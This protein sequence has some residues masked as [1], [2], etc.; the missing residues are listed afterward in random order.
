MPPLPRRAFL[1]AVRSLDERRFR[2]FV[3]DIWAARGYET[4]IDGHRIVVTGPDGKATSLL[5]VADRGWLGRIDR[6]PETDDRVD[7][8]VSVDRHNGGE[9]IATEHH[10]TL[11]DVEELRRITLYAIDRDRAEQLFQTYLNR[12]ATIPPQ[13]DTRFETGR[14]VWGG[15][16]V[17]A[18]VLIAILAAGSVVPWL[19]TSVVGDGSGD[20]TA[21]LQTGAN[22]GDT[23]THPRAE[24]VTDI[25]TGT[26]TETAT[27]DTDV[28]PGSEQTPGWNRPLPAI[29]V[30]DTAWR[31]F[32]FDPAR[33][34]YSR[35]TS[36]PVGNVSIAESVEFDFRFIAS[37]IVVDGRLYATDFGGNLH[38]LNAETM[39]VG[40]RHQLNGRVTAT[41]TVAND[42]LYAA[43]ARS[44]V[45]G[46]RSYA[47]EPA[48][49]LHAI[50][51]D[52]GSTR[53]LRLFEPVVLSSP[54][55]VD[56]TL[57]IGSIEG[58][59]HAVG[60]KNGTN[61]WNTTIGGQLFS[62]PAIAEDTLYIGSTNGGVYAIERTT[63][64]V[65]WT[66]QTNG[67]VLSSPAIV[68]DT[69]YIGSS[70]GRLYALDAETG[71][72]RWNH[73]TGAVI[74]SSPAVAKGRVF[75][76][77]QAGQVYAIDA[78]NG[79]ERWNRTYRGDVLSSP[80][81]ASDTVY[82][83]VE[84]LTEPDNGTRGGIVALDAESG[85]AKWTIE[86]AAPVG[87]S[88][89]VVDGTVFIGDYDGTLYRITG[90]TE[91]ETSSR[92]AVWLANVACN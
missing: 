18:M 51:T 40:W 68:N 12:S 22:P 84:V 32:G 91:L 57:Y 19:P 79:T 65:R 66:V 70:D 75:V 92:E 45:T 17:I 23:L 74:Y 7:V 71:Q 58:T 35:A 15:L 88:P 55:I 38:G 10:A 85:A 44:T 8:V 80:A 20:G 81:V 25:N 16:V 89:A 21:P 37:P 6:P 41:P 28:D 59:V 5:P 47:N 53:W 77:N 54:V 2:A 4:A 27:I 49:T 43:T 64:A 67:S 24:L 86:T 3:A 73:S 14:A 34:G 87:A 82:V 50:A 76:G 31:G 48:S 60:T 72:P 69:V 46:Q 13:S 78:A 30:A 1:R 83:G 90:C 56:G 63:G 61:R 36:G 9:A 29:G 42:T 62:S 11:I 26:P 33:T 52:D 39:A